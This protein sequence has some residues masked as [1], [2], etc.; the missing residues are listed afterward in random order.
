MVRV[1][2]VMG[3]YKITGRLGKGGM[4]DVFRAQD[5]VL[6][7]EVALK[8]LSENWAQDEV[9]KER[10]EHEAQIMARVSH[11]N[12]V[13]VYSV[14]QQYG[15]F[16]IAMELVEGGGLDGLI[17]QLGRVPEEK[18]L[19]LTKDIVRGLDA[20]HQTGLLHRDIKPA[21]ILQGPDGTAKIVDFGLSLLN[22]ES[23]TEKEIWVTP[24]YAAPET[25]LRSAEDFRTDMYALGATM[26]HMLAGTPPP[27]NTH[28]SSDVLLSSKKSLPS[29][30]VAAPDVSPITCFIVD[31]LMS[32]E[33]EDRFESYAD[34]L[35]AIDQAIETQNNTT[36]KKPSV[37]WSEQRR[38]QIR[39]ARRRLNTWIGIGVGLILILCGA[40]MWFWHNYQEAEKDGSTHEDLLPSEGGATIPTLDDLSAKETEQQRA[41]R[42]NRLYADAQSAVKNGDVVHAAKLY[43]DLLEQ[44]ECPL[45]TVLWSGLNQ[46]LCLWV[47]GQYPDGLARLNELSDKYKHHADKSEARRSAKVGAV[48]DLLLNAQGGLPKGI[49]DEELN[50]LAHVGLALKVWNVSGKWV[51]FG[52]FESALDSM[53]TQEHAENVFELAKAWQSNLATHGNQY[54]TLME[55]HDMPERTVEEWKN[56][57]EA[58]E[59]LRDQMM[60]GLAASIP[61]SYAAVEGMLDHLRMKEEDIRIH[62]A[63]EAKREQQAKYEEEK[64]KKAEKAKLE[65]EQKKQEAL[66]KRSYEKVCREMFALLDKDGDYEKAVEF[67]KS[68]EEV[69]NSTIEKDKVRVRCEMMEAMLPFIKAMEKSLPELMKKKKNVKFQLKDETWVRFKGFKG[70]MLEVENEKKQGELIIWDRLHYRSLYLVA[71]ECQK[72]ARKEFTPPGKILYEPLLIFARLTGAMTVEQ[73]NKV[74]SKMSDDFKDQ[75]KLWSEFLK[76]VSHHSE[77]TGDESA[78]IFGDM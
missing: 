13:K 6:G 50:L 64:K 40:G 48:I 31:K 10:F 23:D 37:K 1:K 65:A 30:S 35:D 8:V 3:P 58:V 59:E 28:G 39:A 25:L 36:E 63:E 32:Y 76:P 5:A 42:F 12:L 66:R 14:G 51:Q 19:K 41:E 20:A 45:S 17:N 78:N 33:L 77:G 70:G 4:S 73:E 46:V 43:G 71:R 54:R 55:I 22:S 60:N 18:V 75:W 57:K 2:D 27:V 11:E 52:E 47:N 67:L 9:R 61:A 15:M 53:A 56:K 44:N 69:L 72:V 62:E 68:T 24:Y 21:N 74:L 49:D 16:Y 38:R 26:F 29:L 7:R 34:L